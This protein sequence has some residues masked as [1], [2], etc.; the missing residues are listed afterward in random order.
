MSTIEVDCWDDANTL[1]SA[2]VSRTDIAGPRSAWNSLVARD[3]ETRM[4]TS[5]GRYGQK[6]ARIP[7][8]FLAR[9][10]LAGA[11]NGNTTASNKYRREQGSAILT[12]R[13]RNLGS[14][15]C[16]DRMA[17]EWEGFQGAEIQEEAS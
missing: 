9:P 2:L 7:G 5:A 17:A 15:T 14:S 4:D 16:D 10:Y 8:V 12:H 3:T 13:N 6:C 11:V 1:T